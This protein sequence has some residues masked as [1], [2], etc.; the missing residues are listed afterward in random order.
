M[1]ILND[2][3]EFFMKVKSCKLEE[4]KN[5]KISVSDACDLWSV[6]FDGNFPHSGKFINIFPRESQSKERSL[7]C[8]A[9]SVLLRHV[10]K[11]IKI[12]EMKS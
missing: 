7:M 11:C 5:V 12:L 6:E 4:S 3:N 10:N 9:I 1:I 8:E 2:L